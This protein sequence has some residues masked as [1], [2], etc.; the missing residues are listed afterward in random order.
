VGSKKK[1]PRWIV[2]LQ[3]LQAQ[4]EG[5]SNSMV[6][7]CGDSQILRVRGFPKWVPLKMNG[8]CCGKSY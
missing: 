3:S 2:I 7:G 5:Q 6:A 1:V 8:S 4:S